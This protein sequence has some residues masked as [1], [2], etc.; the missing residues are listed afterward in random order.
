[1]LVSQN[2][3]LPQTPNGTT[4]FAATNQATINNQGQLSLTSGGGAPQF[5]DVPAFANQPTI[6]IYNWKAN[7]LSVTN[8]SANNNTPILVQ[9]V[10]PG[11]PGITPLSLQIGTGLS[12]A[13]GQCAQGNASPQWM[14]LLIQSTA[15]TLGILALIGGPPDGSGNNGYVIAVNAAANTGP[16]T[17]VTPPVGYYATTT[18]NSYAFQFNWGS[19]L[20]F[21]ANMSPST[22]QALTVTMRAL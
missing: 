13:A 17:G 10:G 20:V 1:V 9:A 8:V 21:V 4:V 16:N 18:S 11:M 3:V 19:S 5:L 2:V 22:A 14:Q 6:L 15:A 7:N 12:M